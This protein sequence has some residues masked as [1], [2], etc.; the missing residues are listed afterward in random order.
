MCDFESLEALTTKI[1]DLQLRQ[2]QWKI[3][4]HRKDLEFGPRVIFGTL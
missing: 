1:P 4:P 3:P 2:H